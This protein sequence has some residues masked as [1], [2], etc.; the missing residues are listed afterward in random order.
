MIKVEIN[1]GIGGI[2]LCTKCEDK[3]DI[4]NYDKW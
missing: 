1:N 2:I 3:K 4:T